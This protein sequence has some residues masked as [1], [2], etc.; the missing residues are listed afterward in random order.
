ME[1]KEIQIYTVFLLLLRK[2]I[3]VTHLSTQMHKTSLSWDMKSLDIYSFTLTLWK[4][5]FVTQYNHTSINTV[6]EI[7]L[8]C[9]Q[10]VQIYTILLLIVEYYI[11]NMQTTH[12]FQHNAQDSTIMRYWKVQRCT[13]PF[14]HSARDYQ[15]Y[16][17]I[18]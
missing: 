4:F 2:F 14:Q 3:F 12:I 16:Y 17:G 10:E 15:Y 18:N 1:Y 7:S 6:H 13:C 11:C 5:V 9:G 8:L